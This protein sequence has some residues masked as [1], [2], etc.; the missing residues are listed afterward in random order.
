MHCKVGEGE[1]LY[2]YIKIFTW[3]LWLQFL[4]NN[5]EF[6]TY[7][8]RSFGENFLHVFVGSTI[9]NC[10][11]SGHTLHD[12]RSE[13]FR[14]F[15]CTKTKT[16]V[17]FKAETWS[18]SA[19]TVLVYVHFFPRSLWMLWVILGFSVNWGSKNEIILFKSPSCRVWYEVFTFD[20]YPFLPYNM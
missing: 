1:F 2:Q 10:A 19:F 6:I 11:R 13:I 4:N 20:Y 3:I 9:H 17:D 18:T 7:L 16:I 14:I 15:F 5:M 12:T 8:N